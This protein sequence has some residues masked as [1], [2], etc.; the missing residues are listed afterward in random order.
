MTN[1][2]DEDVY[3]G[4][5]GTVHSVDDRDRRVEVWTLG[6]GHLGVDTWD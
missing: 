2:Y 6:C 3:N 5:L 1:N 4:D